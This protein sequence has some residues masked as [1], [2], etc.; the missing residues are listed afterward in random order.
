VSEQIALGI[1]LG[2][3]GAIAQLALLR[4]RERLLVDGR[5]RLA[6]S[7]LVLAY[8][9]VIA[10]LISSASIAPLVVLASFVGLLGARTLVFEEPAPSP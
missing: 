5:V 10:A 4:W 9:V 7:A 6:W 3:L 8:A 2:V 1:A